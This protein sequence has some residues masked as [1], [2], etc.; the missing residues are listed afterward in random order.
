MSGSSRDALPDV[1]VWSRGPPG[2]PGVVGKHSRMSGSCRESVPDV[3]VVAR[4][5]RMYGN[6]RERSR[7]S[8]GCPGVVGSP[9][10]MS[11]SGRESL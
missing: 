11:R 10:R 5:S 4:P 6:G 7:G 1:L 9:S 2:C 3:R 8:P